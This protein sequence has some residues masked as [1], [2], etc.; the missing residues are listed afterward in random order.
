MQ[1]TE[2]RKAAMEAG[3]ALMALVPASAVRTIVMPIIL[4]GIVPKEN[5][6]CKLGGLRLL[7]QLSER[8]PASVSASLPEVVPALTE[9]MADA[10]PQV[11][12]CH[13]GSQSPLC[14]CTSKAT[15]CMRKD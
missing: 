2:V 11:K 4:K 8:L 9:T 7:D 15:D 5:W 12:V 3:T 14:P 10:K 13:T 6:M 1:N